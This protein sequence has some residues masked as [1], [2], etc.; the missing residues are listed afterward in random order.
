MSQFD[1]YIKIATEMINEANGKKGVVD[2]DMTDKLR[3]LTSII[4]KYTELIED[5]II[6]GSDVVINDIV[7]GNKK[8]DGKYYMLGFAS[9]FSNEIQS[10]G[11]ISTSRQTAKNRTKITKEKVKEKDLYYKANFV[12][13]ERLVNFLNNLRIAD[14][15]DYEKV[16]DD[17]LY[18]KNL[19][20]LN[21]FMKEIGKLTNETQ[22]G[23]LTDETQA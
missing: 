18:L 4:E 14:L 1:K 15:N 20:R 17:R 6:D 5:E 16:L 23:N 9:D 12:L 21:H 19:N 7:K 10:A 13:T 22:T 3:L 8:D 2:T 11:L